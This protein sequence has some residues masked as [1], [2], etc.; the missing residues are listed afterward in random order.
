MTRK[1]DRIH[2]KNV[3]HENNTTQVFCSFSSIIIAIQA[4]QVEECRKT[5]IYK[6]IS[7]LFRNSTQLPHHRFHNK[8]TGYISNCGGVAVGVLCH[9]STSSRTITC[10]ERTEWLGQRKCGKCK[11]RA[12]IKTIDTFENN[13][14]F[15]PNSVG[16][17]RTI[18][19]EAF[20]MTTQ[21]TISLGKME[22]TMAGWYF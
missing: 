1:S 12:I 16:S 9:T 22:K 10:S 3:D 8:M 13:F 5:I 11:G 2:S 7:A 20:S 17:S 4:G 14:R 18:S 15:L 21:T 19:G 6:N